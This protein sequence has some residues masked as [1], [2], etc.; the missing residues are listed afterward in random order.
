VSIEKTGCWFELICDACGDRVLQAFDEIWEIA[1]YK[2]LNGW[3]SKK[4]N[5]EWEDVCPYC[6][7]G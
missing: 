7:E 6:Q 4:R 5:G 3:T 2:K 1:S